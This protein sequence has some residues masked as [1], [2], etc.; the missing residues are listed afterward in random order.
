[1]VALCASATG[2]HETASRLHGAADALLQ[3]SGLGA[4]MSEPG[5]QQLQSDR[6]TLRANAAVDFDRLY[7]NGRQLRE[8]QALRLATEFVS[9]LEQGND[10]GTEGTTRSGQQI[11][12]S[13]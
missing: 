1:M 6:E 5:K 10:R 8:E 2:D 12:P 13:G 7:G 4:S 11:A 9:R 3:R